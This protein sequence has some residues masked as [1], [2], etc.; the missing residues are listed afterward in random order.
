MMITRTSGSS[1]AARKAREKLSSIG[2]LIAF[3]RSGRLS[4]TVAT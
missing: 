2:P 4:V 1:W 3:R